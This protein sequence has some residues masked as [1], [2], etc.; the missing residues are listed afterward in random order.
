ML[1]LGS[2]F[3]FYSLRV[4][5]FKGPAAPNTAWPSSVCSWAV[6]TEPCVRFL[7]GP[8]EHGSRLALGSCDP[9]NS[10]LDLKTP[11]AFFEDS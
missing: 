11:T 10:T 8:W 6:K 4:T 7:K 9:S 2:C 1:V 5:G 3:H